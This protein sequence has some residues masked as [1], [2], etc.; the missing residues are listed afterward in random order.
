MGQRKDLLRVQDLEEEVEHSGRRSRRDWSWAELHENAVK[1]SKLQHGDCCCDGGVGISYVAVAAVNPGDDRAGT[2]AAIDDVGGSG[3]ATRGILL[4]SGSEE[5][6]PRSE[7]RQ[8]TF[9]V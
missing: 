8:T 4:H 6:S 5:S 3:D 7:T 9:D 2:R 1:A